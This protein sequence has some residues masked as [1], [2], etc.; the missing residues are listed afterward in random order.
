MSMKNNAQN[1]KEY[2]IVIVIPAY[3]VEQEIESCISTLPEFIRHI[4]VI[5]DCSPDQTKS[6]VERI[7]KKDSRIVLI[8]H[9]TNQGVGGAMV[10]GFR[11]AL[12]LGAQVVIKLDGDGQMDPQYIPELVYP[13]IN[14]K[15]D[16]TKGNRF[17]DFHALAHMP[18]IRRIGNL[19]LSFLTKIATGYWNCFDPTNGF[20]AIRGDVL[21][22]LPMD[23][24]D[25][26]YFF[27]TSML[28]Y[29][30]LED[31][32]IHDI[33]IPSLYNNGK[34]NLSIRRTLAEFPVK[35]IVSFLKRILLKYFLYDFSIISVYLLVGVPLFLFGLIFGIIKWINYARLYTPAP[36]GT[37]MLATLCV[38][39][40]IQIL[41]SAIDMDIKSVPTKPIGKTMINDA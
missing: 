20:L 41:L 34:S 28:S 6:I 21:S 26:T 11:K 33:P 12:E 31:A 19:G 22:Q 39:L 29:L 15:A 10:S 24:I 7:A 27:E 3:K 16:Y 8:S 30:Y 37:V 36:T 35:L 18:F 32:C 9:D 2:N 4:I 40:G 5:N 17:H 25:R 13:L 38:I 14:G 23:K 1:L